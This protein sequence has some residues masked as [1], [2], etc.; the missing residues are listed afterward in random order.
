MMDR[1]VGFKADLGALAK[2]LPCMPASVVYGHVASRGLDINRWSFGLDTGCV[3][4]ICI[5]QMRWWP[6][7]PHCAGLRSE[8]DSVGARPSPSP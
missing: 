3:S 2:G 5:P 4:C 6:L 1:C 7:M 8:V